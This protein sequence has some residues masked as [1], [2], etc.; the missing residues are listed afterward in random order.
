[1]GESSEFHIFL[2][3]QRTFK[4]FKKAKLLMNGTFVVIYYDRQ[5]NGSNF[6]KRINLGSYPSLRRV[7]CSQVNETQPRS[8]GFF[9]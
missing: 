3:G 7:T 2:N 6:M 4:L 5:N 8:Q 9:P 1:M